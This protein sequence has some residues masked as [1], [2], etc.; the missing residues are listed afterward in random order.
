MLKKSENIKKWYW[1][2]GFILTLTAFLI[3]TSCKRG[4][5]V[6]GMKEQT[7]KVIVSTE[8]SK[9]P[10]DLTTQIVEIK[11]DGNYID[12]K[13]SSL[14]EIA[15]KGQEWSKVRGKWTLL[16]A[17]DSIPYKRIDEIREILANAGVYFITQSTVGSNE[18]VYPA[19][20]V[21]KFAKFSQ[22]DFEA[23]FNKLM[24]SPE[25][26]SIKGQ[27]HITFGFIIDRDGKV[28]DAHIIKGTYSLEKDTALEK[29]LTQIP[30][31]EPAMK[32][33]EKVSVYY[34]MH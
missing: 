3:L 11:T 12:N 33:D 23:W 9:K 4:E 15:L 1:K 18:I 14:E 31:W 29:I 21:S 26:I 19:G 5:K 34:W 25:F 7:E 13:L 10:I 6:P 16:L 2:L 28:K 27:Q 17:D 20:D 24:N 32:G 22:G 30:D 8:I